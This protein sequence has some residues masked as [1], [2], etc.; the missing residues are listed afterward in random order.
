MSTYFTVPEANA[1][2]PHIAPLLEQVQE[3]RQEATGLR[4]RVEEMTPRPRRNGHSHQAAELLDDGRKLRDLRDR[5]N[6]AVGRVVAMGVEVKDLDQGL[7]DFPSIRE[8]REIYLCWR[9]GE[10]S[11]EHWHDVDSGFQ[12]RQPL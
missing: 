5:I 3:W 4:S 9:L 6:A 7:V 12:G 2:L 10:Q 11:V 8:G 1:M